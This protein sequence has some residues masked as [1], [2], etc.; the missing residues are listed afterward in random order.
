MQLQKIEWSS[1]NYNKETPA[2]IK[3]IYRALGAL[4]ALWIMAIEPRVHFSI[5]IK[6]AI[7]STAAIGSYAIYYFC[8]Y[9]GFKE[10]EGPSSANELSK[11]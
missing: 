10:P 8:Q 7:T 3:I 9:F 1:D 11:N 6:Y 5:E 2:F 4:T